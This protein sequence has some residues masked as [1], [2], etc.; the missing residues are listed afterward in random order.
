MRVSVLVCSV[1]SVV[2]GLVRQELGLV[3]W[4]QVTPLDV[5]AALD[6]TLLAF[7]LAI[8]TVVAFDIVRRCLG[9]VLRAWQQRQLLHAQLT[10][11]AEQELITVA[12]WRP[13]QGSV[14][15]V[16]A[17]PVASSRRAPTYG[18]PT[19]GARATGYSRPYTEDPGW[20]L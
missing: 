4:S 20:Q 10:E 16:R 1:L 8:A 18:P 6:E 19:R 15:S 2:F 12:S 17:A 13:Q 5:V 7:V 9:P 3:G 11:F 14:D